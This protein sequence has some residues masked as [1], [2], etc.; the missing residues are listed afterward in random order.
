MAIIYISLGACIGFCVATG[1]NQIFKQMSREKKEK[2]PST[3]P[4]IY[5]E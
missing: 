2:A 1:V 5:G 4:Y 3:L